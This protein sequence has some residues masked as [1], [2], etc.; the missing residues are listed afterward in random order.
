[1][2]KIIASAAIRG[3][4]TIA[5]RVEQKYAAVLQQYGPEQSIGFPNT[6]YFL[7]VIYAILGIP[8]TTLGD[9]QLV[10]KKARRLLPAP[11]SQTTHLPYLAPALDAGMA[12]LFYQEIEEALRYLTNPSFYQSGE[13]VSNGRIW[14]GAAD[15]VIMRKR[16][17]EFV[18]GS[19]PGFASILGAAPDQTTAVRLAQELQVKNLYVF[20]AGDHNGARFAEQL[21]QAGVQIGWNTRLVPFGPDVSS[22][23]FAFGFAVRAAMA[24]G[25]IQPGDFRNILIYNKDRIFAFVLALGDVTDEWYATAAGAIN[26]GFPVIADTPIPQILPTGICTYEH[27]V[28]NVPYDQ[29]VAR[30][31]EV[32]GLKVSVTEVPIPVAYGPAFEGERVRGD[33]IYLEAGGGRTPMV[34]LSEHKQMSQIEDGKIV[35]I[36]PDIP[37][38]PPGS[39]V[40]LG[41]S[42]AFAGRQMQEDFLPILERQIHHLINYAQGVMH[43]GQRD[44][45]WLRLSKQAVAKGFTLKDIGAILHTMFHKNFGTIVD[46]VQITIYTREQDVLDMLTRARDIFRMRDERIAGMTDETEQT[47]YSCTLCQ[48]FAPAHVCVITPERTGLCGAYN[49]LDCKAAYEINPTGP[50]QPIEKG[51][52]LDAVAGSFEGINAFI[53]QASRNKVQRINIYSIMHDPMTSCGCFECISA[54]LDKCNGIMTVDRDYTG[55]TPSGMKFTTLAGAVGGGNITPGFIGH[56]KHYICSRKFLQAEGGIVRI[57]WMPR[58]LKEELR[59]RIN[60]QGAALGVN[61]FADKIADETVGTTQDAILPFLRSV[62]H[63]AL[64]M[65]PMT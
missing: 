24:F 26:F 41:L 55:E 8:V 30:A 27:V 4:Y 48:S 53:R 65:K 59:E 54:F 46:K 60:R 47:F 31:I 34:E 1:M 58:H 45:A 42:V 5:A 62:E 9:C 21:Q 13:D 40:P 56:S 63:P 19:A 61:N 43:I 38:I 20:M 17:V 39:K 14:L 2:S 16:G 57:V 33:D 49:W 29:M 28:S 6:A 18:D 22:A 51:Q 44:I 64:T 11:V 15:D 3:A 32:R 12:T 52:V 25:S 37:D 7:P 36:G 23:V 10:F 35:V 50:N